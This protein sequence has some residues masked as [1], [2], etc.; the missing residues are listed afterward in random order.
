MNVLHLA[1]SCCLVCE[2]RMREGV[3]CYS[4]MFDSSLCVCVCLCLCLCV[5]VCVGWALLQGTLTL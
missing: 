2:L 3:C 4:S 1:N 5:C